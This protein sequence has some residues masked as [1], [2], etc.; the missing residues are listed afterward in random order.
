MIG[1]TAQR[2]EIQQIFQEMVVLLEKGKN[3]DSIQIH[4]E[5]VYL[6]WQMGKKVRDFLES[7]ESQEKR[8]GVLGCLEREFEKRYGRNLSARYLTTMALFVESFP[9]ENILPTNRSLSWSQLCELS[10]FKF[11]LVY[12]YRRGLQNISLVRVGQ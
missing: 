9:E 3:W 11:F 12:L 8:E 5:M 7:L 10:H 1:Q 2:E 6:Y 4:G